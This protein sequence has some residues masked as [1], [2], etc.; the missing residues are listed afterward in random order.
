MDPR[1]PSISRRDF[2]RRTAAGAGGVG[3]AAAMG[4]GLG[5]LAGCGHKPVDPPGVTTIDF[6]TYASPEFLLLWNEYL[7]PGFEKQHPGVKVRITTSMGDQGYDAK[8]LTL[9]AGKL[10]P[11]V[12]HVTQGNFPFYANK[13]MLLE[14]DDLIA[15]DRAFDVNELLPRVV[16]A[17][18]WQG[19][20]LVGLP[21]DFSPVVICYNKD[22]FDKAGVPYPHDDWTWDEFLDAAKKLT[23]DVNGDGRKDVYGFVNPDAYNRWPAWVWM[24]G[25]DVFNA[26]ASRC[27]MDTPEAIGGMKFY[28]DLSQAHGVAPTASEAMGQLAIPQFMSQRVAMIADARYAYKNFT[29]GK[30]LPFRWDV[31]HMPRGKERATTFIW[32]GNCILKD[33]PHPKEAYEFVKFITGELGAKLNVEAGNALP[34]HRKVAEAA[35]RPQ[36]GTTF[37]EHDRIYLE[38]LAYARQAPFPPQTAEFVAALGNLH[39]AYLG[40]EPVDVACRR[41]TRE[42]NSFLGSEVV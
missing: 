20:K 14:L 41:F 29:R 12:F 36:P 4:A 42:V 1:R 5:G 17:M 32:G 2:L 31:A 25:G 10:A 26:D 30:G 18:R 11:D 8:L 19:N 9:I 34:P 35:V 7:I 33:T 40:I 38:A 16:D 28:A 39:D 27:T 24:N 6:F 13:G 22:L 21:S 3:A 23:R 37:P 15:A